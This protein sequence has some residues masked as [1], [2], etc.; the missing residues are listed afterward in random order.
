MIKYN[1]KYKSV[2]PIYALIYEMNKFYLQDQKYK[3]VNDGF[4]NLS[5]TTNIQEFLQKKFGFKKMPLRLYMQYNMPLKM[6]VQV[7][8]PIR[9]S[10]SKIHHKIKYLFVL[11]DIRRSYC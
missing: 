5:H 2:Y 1:P 10:I 6:A 8:Y 3:Y 11:E 9:K 4:R 7:L